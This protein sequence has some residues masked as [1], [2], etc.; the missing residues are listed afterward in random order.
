MDERGS[1]RERTR[2][3]GAW[4]R[5]LLGL[6][7]A[8][9]A[10]AFLAG[11][12]GAGSRP[13]DARSLACAGA[14]AEAAASS[15][16]QIA[17]HLRP[18]RP[19]TPTPTPSPTPSPTP[20][21]VPSG[22]V[23]ETFE[24]GAAIFVVLG[25]AGTYD[26]PTIE[27]IVQTVQ[28]A[29][30]DPIISTLAGTFPSIVTP[31]A[32]GMKIDFGT[33]F[34]VGNGNVLAGSATVTFSNLVSSADQVSF[35]CSASFAGFRRNG[36][37]LPLD[38]ASGS[39]NVTVSGGHVVGD[40]TATG[41]GAEPRGAV[42]GAAS[43]HVDTAKCAKYPTSGSV[44]VTVAGQTKTIAFNNKCDGTFDYD[45][46]FAQVWQV[47][48]PWPDCY[49]NPPSIGSGWYSPYVVAENGRLAV[50]PV[51]GLN[52]PS[53][54]G[55]YTGS[56][57]H[58]DLEFLWNLPQTSFPGRQWEQY[59]VTFDGALASGGG[60]YVGGYSVQTVNHRSDGSSR[61]CTYTCNDAVKP[62]GCLQQTITWLTCPVH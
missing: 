45:S 11:L 46:P 58:L 57:A 6:P 31:V 10:V 39:V 38:T 18:A 33:G 47:D 5:L 9:A 30:I 3:A 36:A 1:W 24:V 7:L 15:G 41:A 29:G 51:A 34:T 4:L 50:K 22:P 44:G 56:D 42:S 48:M 28:A 16:D 49:S 8:A 60:K 35:D 52:T 61:T 43:A 23:L 19:A 59:R 40:L 32:N 27:G 2:G 20:T 25:Q 26:I 62:C 13:S 55:W 17:R 21:P 14:F 54:S 53:G 37:L 12:P